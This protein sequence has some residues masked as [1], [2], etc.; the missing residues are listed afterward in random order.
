MMRFSDLQ[1]Q[2]NCIEILQ[3]DVFDISARLSRTRYV[4]SS[5][6]TDRIRPKQTIA[7]ENVEEHFRW[8]VLSEYWIH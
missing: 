4:V 7:L 3:F 8:L 5:F 2:S 6:T 1:E